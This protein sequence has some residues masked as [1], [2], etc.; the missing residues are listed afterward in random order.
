MLS[1]LHFMDFINDSVL[2]PSMYDKG[3]TKFRLQATTGSA[4]HFKD[5]RDP[6]HEYY[7]M[8]EANSSKSTGIDT[9][10]QFGVSEANRRRFQ[11]ELEFIQCLANPWYLHCT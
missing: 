5:A 4:Y 9:S 8:E 3:I 2:I 1:M 7:M 10:P 11:M 6:S